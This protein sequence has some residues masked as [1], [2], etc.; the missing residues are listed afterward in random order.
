MS[1][2]PG[3]ETRQLYLRPF[4]PADAHRVKDLAGDR[5]IADVTAHIPHPYPEGL[6]ER[7]IATH[8]DLWAAGEAAIF[9][10]ARRADEQVIGCASITGIRDGEGEIGY[11][12]GVEYWGQGYCTEA[13]R[14]LAGFAF[15]TLGLKRLHSHHLVRNPAS[16]RV[17]AK[18]GFSSIGRRDTLC[19]YR[20]QSEPAEFYELLN[21]S[22]Q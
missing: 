3:L 16:G 21:R 9:A 11:W 1:Q 2:Q 6:A 15:D 13:V 17:L 10:V 19:G 4:S 14:A 12:V 20:R 7:W 18:T 8:S 22:A 5:R